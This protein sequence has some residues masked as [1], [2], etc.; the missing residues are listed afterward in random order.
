MGI[1]STAVANGSALQGGATTDAAHETNIRAAREARRDKIEFVPGSGAIRGV[2]SYNG[3]KYAFRDNA[4]ATAGVMYESS[5]AGWQ[6]VDL[7][8][9]I[10]FTAGTTEFEEGE[11][12]TGSTSGA[13]GV[14]VAVGVSTGTWSGNDTAGNL[15][16]KTISGTF[17]AETITS[18]SG[19]ATCSGAQTA[20][21]LPTGGHYE[22]HNINFGGQL[23]TR[24]MWGCNAVGRSFRYDG[25][26][27]AFNHV[28]GLSSDAPTHMQAH[29]SH[30]FVTIG[31]SLIISS[32]GT[33]MVW[34]AITGA[35]EIATG[36]TIVGIDLQAG[37]VLAVYNRNSTYLLYGSDS[38]TWDLKE[39][40]LDRG[41]IEYS[42]QNLMMPLYIDDRGINYLS[43]TQKFGDYKANTISEIIDPLIQAYK[44]K[45]VT[46]VRI[47]DKTQVRWFFNDGTALIIRMSGS[48]KV[49][50][51]PMNYGMV[52]RAICAEENSSG[53]EEVFFGSDDGYIYQAEKGNSFDGELIEYFM[54]YPFISL[55]ADRQKFRAH[56]AT[57]LLDASERPVLSYLPEFSFGNA[58]IPISELKSIADGSINTGGGYWDDAIWGEFVWDGPAVGEADAYIDGQG[59]NISLTVRGES[60]YESQHTI[61]SC[62]YHYTPRG[63]RR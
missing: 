31:S 28:T 20:V 14:I 45:L 61:Q 23:T 57:F 24:H 30:M 5:A 21:A 4:G 50:Y 59:F 13:I 52:V 47:K 56:K 6:I 27:F 15:Y 53:N 55:A 48:M 33:P 37:D 32:I 10:A 34:D 43:T 58:D 8:N 11:T 3:T 25:T 17:Q 22:F 12:V 38:A 29:N 44:D 63:L 2:W 26:D 18:A 35:A 36:D 19:S 42:L 7:G 49:E 16:I 62:T 54:R 51:M 39:F 9:Y 46:S 60:N 40:S 1:I 41:A